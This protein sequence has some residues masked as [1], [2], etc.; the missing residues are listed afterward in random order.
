MDTSHICVP[1]TWLKRDLHALASAS[2]VQ[3]Y[4]WLSLVQLYAPS[5]QCQEVGP[6]SIALFWSAAVIVL[7]GCK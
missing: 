5:N 3:A 6:V 4:L 1:D 7:L 2:E